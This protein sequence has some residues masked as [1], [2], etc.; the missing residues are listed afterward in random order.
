MKKLCVF[1]MAIALMAPA[2]LSRRLR[3][4]RPALVTC[5]TPSGF[6]SFTPGL[7]AN[8]RSPDDDL[9]PADHG[10]TGS[11][12]VK[13]GT[14][15]GSPKGTTKQT[16]ATFAQA[17][18][19]TTTVTITWNT[20]KTSTA[21]LATK[22]GQRAGRPYHGHGVR[23][24][25]QGSVHRQDSQDEGQGHDLHGRSARRKPAEEGDA[26][27]PRQAVTIG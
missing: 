1:G 6:V 13:S 4:A 14:S 17:G 25:Q 11:G 10:C 22:I 18:K 24:D 23:Q 8:R 3:P 21:K 19:T 12:G 2:G 9:Q 26:D 15:K 20:K 27:R 7:G 5:A 16:C